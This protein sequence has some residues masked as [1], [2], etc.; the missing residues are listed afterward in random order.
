MRKVIKDT[1]DTMFAAVVIIGLVLAALNSHDRALQTGAVI[2]LL[3]LPGLLVYRLMTILLRLFRRK[4]RRFTDFNAMSGL[5]FEKYVAKVLLSRGY[6]NVSLTER[7]DFGIDIIATKDNI[8]WGI[9]VKRHQHMVKAI[10][11]RQAV[12]AL[13]K[14]NC[15]RAMVITNSYYSGTAIELARVNDCVLVDGKAFTGWSI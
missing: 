8:K 14:Y 7:Y 1:F 3:I 5:E 9:Q 13:K 10:A 2:F 6:T 12:T 4:R 15:D 11:V